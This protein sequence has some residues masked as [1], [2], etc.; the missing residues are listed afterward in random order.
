MFYLNVTVNLSS[1]GIANLK[2]SFFFS[3]SPTSCNYTKN[4]EYKKILFYA[5]NITQ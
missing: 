3:L 4:I 1:G 5:L 2:T